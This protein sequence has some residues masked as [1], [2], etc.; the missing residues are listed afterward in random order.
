MWNGGFGYDWEE[1]KPARG[2]ERELSAEFIYNGVYFT[3]EQMNSNKSATVFN[4]V[5]LLATKV[6]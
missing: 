2:Y 4:C 6:N 1:E 5:E 3:V